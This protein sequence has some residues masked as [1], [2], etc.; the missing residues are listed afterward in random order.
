MPARFLVFQE[1]GKE[2]AILAFLK[3]TAFASI[4]ESSEMMKLAESMEKDML[5]ISEELIG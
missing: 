3:P 1:E 2:G 4:F 5:E